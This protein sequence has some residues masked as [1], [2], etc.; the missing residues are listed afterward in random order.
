MFLWAVGRRRGKNAFCLYHPI[1]LVNIRDAAYG[2]LNSA[3]S[4]GILE[5][6]LDLHVEAGSA[7]RLRH[8]LGSPHCTIFAVHACVRH[9]D[10]STG[11]AGKKKWIWLAVRVAAAVTDAAV[12]TIFTF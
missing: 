4:P 5:P 1:K 10:G 6:S 7:L 12:Y 2:V 8:T 9:V 3:R 11:R